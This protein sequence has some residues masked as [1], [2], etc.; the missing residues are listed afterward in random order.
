MPAKRTRPFLKWAGGKFEISDKI[1][2]HFPPSRRLL[3]PFVGSG[4]IFVNTER[5]KYLLNDVNA[6]LVNL[7]KALKKNPSDFIQD[8]KR[9]F[10]SRNNSPSAYY[11]LRERFNQITD[12]YEKSLLFLY[13][14]RHGYNGLCRYNRSGKFNVPFGTYAAPYFPEAELA[15]FAK[16][17]RSASLNNLDF[18]LFFKKAVHGDVVYCDPPYIPLSSTSNFSDYAF[19]GFTLK[20]QEILA[21]E[22]RAA[23]ERGVTVVISNHD[24][25]LSRKIYKGA[26]IVAYEVRRNINSNVTR[27]GKVRELVAIFPAK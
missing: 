19:N 25:P 8:S 3:E 23:A 24:T 11:E 22:A 21:Q 12:S 4:A 18:R 16:R 17:L 27:R 14:N 5:K 10:T 6:D 1:A 26:A 20:D 13:L 7:Y 15:Y 9:L 2:G